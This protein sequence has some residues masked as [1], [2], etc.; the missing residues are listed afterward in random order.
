MAA[1]LTFYQGLIVRLDGPLHF[2][3]IAQPAMASFLGIRDGIKN[4][5]AGRPPYFWTI[6]TDFKLG[7]QY[8]R[9]GLRSDVK[10]IVL[11]SLLDAIYQFVAFR[12]FHLEGALYAALILAFLP[13]L[14]IRGPANRITRWC[15]SRRASRAAGQKTIPVGDVR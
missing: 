14:I 5:R 15:A 10:V 9:D 11:A 7:L 1:P 13:Y 4:A 3:F 2:R 6:C 12:S 8:L